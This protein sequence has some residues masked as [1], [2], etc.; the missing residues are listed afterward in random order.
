LP[1]ELTSLLTALRRQ[2]HEFSVWQEKLCLLLRECKDGRKPELEDLR[3]LLDSP[4]ALDYP[5]CEVS[6]EAREI[7]R[8]CDRVVNRAR[9]IM[10]QRTQ[11]RDQLGMRES[12]PVIDERDVQSIGLDVDSLP[13]SVSDLRNDIMVLL[14]CQW[15]K[16]AHKLLNWKRLK[17]VDSDSENSDDHT[18]DG[19]GSENCTLKTF[20][21]VLYS[22][23]K[24]FIMR[25]SPAH[26]CAE[27]RREGIRCFCQRICNMFYL[28]NSYYNIFEILTGRDD[29]AELIE[30]IPM[31]LSPFKAYSI[32]EDWTY[33]ES[34]ESVEQ[35]KNH[36]SSVFTKQREL[37]VALRTANDARSVS[38]TC[39]CAGHTQAE[40]PADNCAF[41]SCLLC[42]A[43]Y[44]SSC[45]QWEW[46]MEHLP[47][48]YYLCVRCLRSRRPLLEDVKSLCETALPSLE[49]V[50]VECALNQ[51]ELVYGEALK[52]IEQFSGGNVIDDTALCKKIDEC[53]IPVFC[54][55]ILKS[56]AW[57]RISAA[58]TQ[59]KPVTEM[60]KRLCEQIRQRMPLIQLSGV[61]FS[62]SGFGLS[63][64]YRNLKRG[65][66]MSEQ[67]AGRHM[68]RIK[69]FGE[70]EACAADICLK[71]S[72]ENVRWI[73][74][75]GNCSRW[76]HYICV[77]QTMDQ[78]QYTFSYYCYRC[79]TPFRT[80]FAS[81]GNNAG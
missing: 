47:V 25:N 26:A 35:L 30:G 70:T 9:A 42:H 32:R 61:L 21:D 24:S 34:F 5:H 44:H 71:P 64:R 73:Q 10:R 74:C 20:D 14:K 16:R 62:G 7:V 66:I 49:R 81:S 40:A 48:G 46:F 57:K 55:E 39:L 60:R 37:M 80:P 12:F 3:G 45:V 27:E 4:L 15:L 36:I 79:C 1:S 22:I 59:V 41:L 11:I 68:K 63:R 58:L 2:T 17:L 78:T 67:S 19:K 8:Q 51:T 13:C 6:E 18:N 38:E 52:C 65:L 54:N 50:L 43:K 72:G 76:Y 29:L 56:E 31:P 75:E 23:R 69:H 53:L 77:G 28:R 33:I